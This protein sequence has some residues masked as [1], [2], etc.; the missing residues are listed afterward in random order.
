MTDDD[1]HGRVADAVA[2][3]R[4]VALLLERAQASGY[5]SEAYRTAARTVEAQPADRVAALADAGSLTDLPGVGATTADVV[6]RV[7]AGRDVPTLDELEAQAR[8]ADDALPDA[9]ARLHGALRGDLHTHTEASDGSAPVQEMVL[10]ALEL[11]REYV[12]VTDHSPRL[13]V[14]HGLSAARLRAQLDQLAALRPAVAPFEV[15][16]GIEVDV[17]DDGTLDQDPDLLDELDVVVASV[18]SKLR[19]DRD[20]MT[21]RMLA[22][23]RDPRTDVLGHCT[24]RR[25]TGRPRPPSDFDARAV[26]DACAEHGVAVEINSRPD[27]LDPP[28]ALLQVAVDAGCEF[29][30]D[31]DAH[32]PGQLDWLRAGCERAAAHG[33]GPERVVTTR[34]AQ[35][36]RAR[37]RR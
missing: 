4:R 35:E 22:A 13:T 17:L 6:A 2:T 15:L 5:R 11:G 24:G 3:L 25:L 26:F 8:A 9:A 27:R 19:M 16:S 21:R 7:L 34:S 31:S 30:I 37:G 14:A 28:H 12:A 32:A 36:V 29:T 1:P 10:A 33:I 20:A 23:V 18:H